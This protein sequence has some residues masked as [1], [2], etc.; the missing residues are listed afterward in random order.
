MGKAGARVMGREF[1]VTNRRAGG[2]KLIPYIGCKSGF[3][4]IFDS[5]IP[6][7][8]GSRIYDVFGGGGGF[9]FY[10]CR[11]FGSENVVYNDHNPT[12]TNLMESLRR[13]PSE[14]YEEYQGHYR[15]SDP[16]YYLGVR[17]MDLQD[18]VAGAGRFFY[19]AK[20]A[21]SGKIRFNSRNEFN[22]PMRKGAR[23]PRVDLEALLDLS[24]TIRNLTVTEEDFAHYADVR[25]GFVYLDP[26]YMN[27]PNGHYNA[28]VS[29]DAFVRFVRQVQGSNMV[30]IS[31]QNEPDR[32]ML[33][34]EY[35]VFRVS[36]RRSL[37]YFT[38]SASSEIVAINY[39]AP[40]G[41]AP[42]D[43]IMTGHAVRGRA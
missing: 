8:Y 26:P 35:S 4:H 30:M 13:H 40:S 31:E 12:I 43:A 39:D 7:R 5:L 27:N 33:S 41:G 11:R 3:S 22:A 32:L 9:A 10:A 20:N 42:H 38:Q 2:L 15:R 24:N 16:D 23:C 25:D 34:S 6:E 28:T 21:F 19:L 18:G 29:P 14:L 1:A 36:L 17:R 37:Q